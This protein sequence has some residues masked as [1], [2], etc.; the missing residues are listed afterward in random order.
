MED[1][2]VSNLVHNLEAE[3]ALVGSVALSRKASEQVVWVK[4]VMF[5][6]PANGEILDAV[7]SVYSNGA[8]ECDLVLL[9]DELRARGTLND[10]GGTDY[11]KQVMESVPSASN[12]SYYAEIVR[13]CWA[14][15]E[16]VARADLLRDQAVKGDLSDAV[17]T[18]STILKGLLDST[19]HE[20]DI[21]DAVESLPTKI[22]PGIPSGFP[23]I[24]R[25]SM[26]GGFYRGESNIIAAKRGGRKSL[27]LCQF[28]RLACEAGFRGAFVSLE[29]DAQT[30]VRRIL[31]Q[32]T[33]FGSFDEAARTGEVF[34]HEYRAAQK[35]MGFWD[36]LI[37]DTTDADEGADTVE[38]VRDWVLAKHTH[39]PLDFVVIDYCQLLETAKPY[40]DDRRKNAYMA[41]V[42]RRLAKK[43]GYVPLYA[44]QMQ[45]FEGQKYVRHSSEWEDGAG[46]VFVT[47]EKDGE[48]IMRNTKNR[49][50]DQFFEFA[51]G[52]DKRSLVTSEAEP[53]AV[54]W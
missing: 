51:L 45:E 25:R 27:I 23:R 32:M 49:H 44:A 20:V 47:F 52:F 42:L 37:Y 33:G 8:G 5:Y 39:R 43:C 18:G 29:M 28:V 12:V 6:Q 4:P 34:A 31:R 54:R 30:V 10:V 16:M 17:E 46:Y 1:L 35:E 53:E 21:A 50:G 41:R 40:G 26:A 14:R 3:T 9:R 15:R 13:E 7:R 38:A 24:D 19:T 22:V 2:R 48:W 11:L 36:L